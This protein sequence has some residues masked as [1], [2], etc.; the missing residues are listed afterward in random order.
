VVDFRESTK[1][2]TDAGML[3]PNDCVLDA[4]EPAPLGDGS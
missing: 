3:V 4:L 1:D 2:P